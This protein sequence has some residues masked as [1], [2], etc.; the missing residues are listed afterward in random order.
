MIWSIDTASAGINAEA[1]DER[2]VGEMS[3]NSDWCE[4]KLED[5][6]MGMSLVFEEEEME[7][8]FWGYLWEGCVNG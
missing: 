4:V 3:L 7:R 1:I 5:T 8:P 6:V 2:R